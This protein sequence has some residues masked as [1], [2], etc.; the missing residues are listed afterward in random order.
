MRKVKIVSKTGPIRLLP[1]VLVGGPV[2]GRNETSNCSV[3]MFLE[4]KLR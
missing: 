2:V 4:Q 1:S 3:S